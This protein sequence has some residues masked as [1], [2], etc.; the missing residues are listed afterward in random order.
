MAQ[1]ALDSATDLR[2]VIVADRQRATR[3]IRTFV[4][5][6]ILF[7][8]GAGALVPVALR[9]PWLWVIVGIILLVAAFGLLI[10][11]GLRAQAGSRVV[12]F[13]ARGVFVPA[14]AFPVAWE[15]IAWL[16]AVQYSNQS[17]GSSAAVAATTAMAEAG[18]ND[19][20]RDLNVVL[21]DAAAM[22]SRLGKTID[23]LVVDNLPW[24]D[25]GVAGFQIYLSN[26][27]DRFGFMDFVIALKAEADR[28][29][30]PFL[31]SNL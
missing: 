29:G 7:L 22:K 20:G 31:V 26:P 12:G 13:S 19:G 16:R 9:S 5:V 6:S 11:F 10:V 8:V 17:G 23:F 2:A 21:K 27:T 3:Q 15:E 18:V 1:S 25:T 30:I 14:L 4:I 28:R 24:E